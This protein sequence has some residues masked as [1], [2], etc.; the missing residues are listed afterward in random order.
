MRN[1]EKYLL[2][3]GCLGMLAMVLIIRSCESNQDQP[4]PDGSDRLL[5]FPEFITPNEEYFETRIAEI[6]AITADSYQLIIFG[7]VDNPAAYSLEELRNL[8]MVERTLTVECIGNPVNG[9]LLGTA[10]WEGFRVYD[11]LKSLGIKDG[12]SAVKYHCADGYYTYNSLEELQNSEVLGAL[13][14]NNESIPAA[15][16]FPLR[17]IFPGYHGVRQPGWILKIELLES[18]DVDYY[19]RSGWHTDSSMAV[20][21]KIFFPLNNT[22]FSL[23]E[24]VKI[25]G[26][27]YGGKRISSVEITLDEGKT[28]IPAITHQSVDQDYVWIFWEVNITPQYA[29]TLTIQSRATARD[30]RTQPGADSEFRDGKNSWPT[31]SISVE[32]GN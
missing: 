32:K 14:M 23:G 6:P 16:G 28:W 30:G 17:I 3:I 12:A 15:Y 7:A 13:Y 20:D 18:E 27:A 24:S 4:F 8:E 11:L 19:S 25:G 21:S 29:G 1:S 2:V 9:N 26:A 31:V 22:R 10:V 5:D